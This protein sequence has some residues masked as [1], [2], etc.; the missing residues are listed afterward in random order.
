MVSLTGCGVSAVVCAWLDQLGCSATLEGEEGR[1]YLLLRLIMA[2]CLEDTA[3][4]GTG[5]ST[6]DSA[7]PVLNPDVLERTCMCVLCTGYTM[8]PHEPEL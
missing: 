2:A 7:P 8:V 3:D 5:C 4:D 6:T 1:V